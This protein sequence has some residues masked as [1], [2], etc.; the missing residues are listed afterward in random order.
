MEA[1]QQRLGYGAWQ[2]ALFPSVLYD[3]PSYK[4][5]LAVALFQQQTCQI[6]GNSTTC[7]KRVH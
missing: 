6:L 1:M 4:H 3:I 2:A 5:D 7:E